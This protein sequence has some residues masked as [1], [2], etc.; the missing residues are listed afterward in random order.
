MY[1]EIF[2]DWPQVADNTPKQIQNPTV[3]INLVSV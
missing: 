2:R 1:L 3:K